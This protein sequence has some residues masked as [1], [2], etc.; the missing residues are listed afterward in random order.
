MGEEAYKDKKTKNQ[1]SIIVIVSEASDYF[2]RD[3]HP[4]WG[5]IMTLQVTL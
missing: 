3:E 5:K 4:L 1:R 2:N